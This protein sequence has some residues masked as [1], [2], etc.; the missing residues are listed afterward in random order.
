MISH[1][2]GFTSGEGAGSISPDSV[3]IRSEIDKQM[4]Y[5]IVGIDRIGLMRKYVEKT[6]AAPISEKEEAI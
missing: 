6:K 1:E 5:L 3:N 4:T 2:V